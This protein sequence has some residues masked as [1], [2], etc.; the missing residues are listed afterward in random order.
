MDDEQRDDTAHAQ[1]VRRVYKLNDT[2]QAHEMKIGE[3]GVLIG[4]L[5]QQVEALRSTTAS[6]EQLDHYAESVHT[7]VAAV[8]T[9]MKSAIGMTAD[10][11]TL[12]LQHLHDDLDPIKRRMDWAVGL[13]VGAVIIALLGLVLKS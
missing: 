12:K 1:L 5:T 2:A 7:K 11:L 10:T 6:R 4:V 9:A 3:H 13:I 8:E